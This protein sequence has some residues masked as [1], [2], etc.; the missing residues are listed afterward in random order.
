MVKVGELAVAHRIYITAERVYGRDELCV[1]T[2][3]AFN[4][5]KIEYCSDGKRSAK[6]LR[7]LKPE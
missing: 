2:S 4:M 6:E 1:V 5:A 3:I 7:D